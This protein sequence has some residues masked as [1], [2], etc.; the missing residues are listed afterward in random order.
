V[1]LPGLSVAASLASLA[2]VLTTV[3]RPLLEV[4]LEG[5]PVVLR[6][7]LDPG[8]PFVL[9]YVHSVELQP[10]WEVYS[11]DPD[12]AVRVR[13]HDFAVFGAGLGQIP[14]EGR[15]RGAPR[16]WTRVVDLDRRVGTFALR[17][18]QP[19]SNHRL[20]VRGR[21]VS[22]SQAYAGKRVWIGGREVSLLRWIT[23]RRPA[24]ASA[25]APWEEEP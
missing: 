10:V 5:G 21:V 4:R 7:A 8:E 17:V 3:H 6:E 14:G 16:G 15:E 13:E 19:T 20:I 12:G 25:P 24:V 18:A 11:L 1:R 23:H 22:L 9:T 2:A